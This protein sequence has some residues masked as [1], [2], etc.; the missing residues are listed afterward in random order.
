[1]GDKDGENSASK[2]IKTLVFQ[3]SNY[4]D[5]ATANAKYKQHCFIE[6]AYIEVTLIAKALLQGHSAT[7]Y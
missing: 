1:M 7:A 6:P 2:Y 5:L 3:T 4:V